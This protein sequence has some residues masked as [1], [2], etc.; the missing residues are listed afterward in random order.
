MII[1]FPLNRLSQ[2][3]QLSMPTINDGTI[4]I[5]I[6]ELDNHDTSYIILNGCSLLPPTIDTGTIFKFMIIKLPR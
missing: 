2:L 3:S 6:L 5:V 1:K 4:F